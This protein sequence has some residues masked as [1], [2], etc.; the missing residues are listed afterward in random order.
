M[1]RWTITFFLTILASTVTY[2][3]ADTVVSR[4]KYNYVDYYFNGK[5][6]SFGNLTDSLK[7]GNWIFYKPDG[8]ILAKGR[9]VYGIAKGK[10]IYHDYDGKQRTYN[11]NWRKGFKPGTTLEL[12]EGKLYIKQ[13]Y[14]FSN[15]VFR[16]FENG[17]YQGGGKF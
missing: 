9:F 5:I 3:Q 10:W 14:I 11:W 2:G 12:R 17:K 7:T 13:N 8:S 4:N 1:T 6:K 16:S 15:G